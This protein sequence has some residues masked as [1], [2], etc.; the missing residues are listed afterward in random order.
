MQAKRYGYRLTGLMTALLILAG[1][2]ADSRYSDQDNVLLKESGESRQEEQIAPGF[3]AGETGFSQNEDERA[4]AHE[5][6]GIFGNQRDMAYVLPD[7]VSVRVEDKERSQE[8]GRLVRGNE[9]QILDIRET[10]ASTWVQ[11]SHHAVES[12]SGWIQA[13]HLT[14]QL[15][16]LSENL[17]D[18]AE[19]NA[20]FTSP[21]LFEVNRVVAYYGHPYT[22]SMGVVGRYGLDELITSLK[23]T[24]Q[25][26]DEADEQ[27]GVLPAIYLAYGT[28]QPGGDVFKI[29]HELVMTYIEAAYQEGVLVYLEHPI[30][31]QDLNFSV[32]ELLPFLRYP[33]VHLALDPGQRIS[34][35]MQE[36]GQ[37]SG[38]EINTVQQT[39]QTYIQKQAIP[40][41]RQFVFPQFVEER[42]EDIKTVSNDFEPVLPVYI[43]NER[44]LPE[45]KL[46]SY[47]WAPQAAHIPYKGIKLRYNSIDQAGSVR[48]P[49]EVLR[50][51]P[52]PSLIIYQ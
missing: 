7:Q 33:N 38:E 31:R 32:Q 34:L 2:T 52:Q 10:E 25:S 48:T 22:E 29:N 45:G 23:K 4:D 16:E 51:D 6:Q 37:L 28:V 19:Q 47:E 21:E 15:T 3:E 5:E 1:C 24:A 8:I 9:V 20:L 43:T 13:E 39:V 44:E 46:T 42:V 40:G 49:Q 11:I 50:L 27:K 14:R 41:I 18:E 12:G 35:P 30:G 26:Y 36:I 17:F